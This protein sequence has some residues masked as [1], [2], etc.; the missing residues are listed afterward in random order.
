MPNPFSTDFTV[1]PQWDTVGLKKLKAME[2][3][4]H[5][6]ETNGKFES[7]HYKEREFDVKQAERTIQQST[8]KEIKDWMATPESYSRGI[9]L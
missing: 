1:K 7:T 2:A 3:A 6:Q 5:A 9:V 8:H 4:K